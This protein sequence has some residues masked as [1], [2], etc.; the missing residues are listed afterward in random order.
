MSQS[1]RTKSATSPSIPDTTVG[2]RELR[3]H[4]SSYL[5]QVKGGK[6]ITV[7]EHGRTIARIVGAQ[8]P[9]ALE[10][11]IAAGEATAPTRPFP[12]PGELP[13]IRL[14]GSLQDLMDEIRS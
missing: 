14:A 12:R 3:D 9:P 7:T 4:L 10:R 2:V 8:M 1:G 13:G 5:E 11:L 6:T